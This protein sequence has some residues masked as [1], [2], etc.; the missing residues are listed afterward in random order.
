MKVPLYSKCLEGQGPEPCFRGG[1]VFKDTRL[2]EHSKIFAAHDSEIES[3][4][5]RERVDLNINE[6]GFQRRDY[7][8]TRLP[9]VCSFKPGGQSS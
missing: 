5:G 3:N 9:R 6:L 7:A 2:L 8:L 1:L 4:T